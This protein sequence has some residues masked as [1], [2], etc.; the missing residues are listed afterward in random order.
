VVRAT[1]RSATVGTF[2]DEWMRADLVVDSLEA[3]VKGGSRIVGATYPRDTSS[4][5]KQAAAPAHHHSGLHRSNAV[6]IRAAVTRPARPSPV[7]CRCSRTHP[8]VVAA[9][10]P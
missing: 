7:V 9:E 10:S 5:V 2:A 4:T 8:D 1:S 6:T 3:L